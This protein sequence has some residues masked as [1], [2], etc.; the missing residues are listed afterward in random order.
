MTMAKKYTTIKQCMGEGGRWWRRA[1]E[2][3]N[4]TVDGREGARRM[5]VVAA[6][7]DERHLLPTSTDDGG[8][9]IVVGG[10]G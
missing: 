10:G 1:D 7:K 9:Q 6:M 2:N 5:T 4:Q 3:D 8:W